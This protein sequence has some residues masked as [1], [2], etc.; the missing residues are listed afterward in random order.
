MN[1]W[2]DGTIV[3]GTRPMYLK[4]IPSHSINSKGII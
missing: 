2:M 4:T 3:Y 1:G